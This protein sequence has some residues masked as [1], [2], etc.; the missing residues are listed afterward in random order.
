MSRLRSKKQKLQEF[1]KCQ[2]NYK[3]FLKTYA[4][5]RHPE[6]GLI[7]F[8]TWDFQD[9]LLDK[10]YNHK[11]NIINKSR[12]LGISTVVAGH[13]AWLMCFHRAKN[14]YITSIKIDTAQLMLDMVRTIIDNLPNWFY[15]FF[16]I[17]DNNKQTLSLSN[18]SILKI[19]P[20]SNAARGQALSLMVIDEAA[21]IEGLDRFWAALQP[22]ITAG[23]RC[24]ILSTPNGTGNFFEKE[25]H[26]ALAGE[27]GFVAT[28][29]P[30]WHHPERDEEWE[31]ATRASTSKREF[32]QEFDCDFAGSG[33]TFIAPEVIAFYEQVNRSPSRIIGRDRKIHIFEECDNSIPNNHIL[34]VDPARG[35]KEEGDPFGFHVVRLSDMTQ[36]AEGQTYLDVESVAKDVIE[37]VRLYDDAMIVV[38]NNGG[39]GIRF[40]E[41]IL[42]LGY[43]NI[44][45]SLKNTGEYIEYEF[46]ETQP[47]AV[48]GL[49]TSPSTRV[50]MMDLMLEFIEQKKCVIFSRRFTREMR[51]FIWK[52][53]KPQ[54]R[55]GKHDDLMMSWAFACF[56]KQYISGNFEETENKMM[57]ALSAPKVSVNYLDTTIPG[58]PGF[59]AHRRLA[60]EAKKQKK[61][62]K[63]FMWL[64]MG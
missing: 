25:F 52:N 46:M 4:R 64:Y 5:I 31:K 32:S 49:N 40:I 30:W 12:Q 43:S 21:F 22:T 59:A 2:K 23:G 8:N 6:R 33:D 55:K 50:K 45:C 26:K 14:I 18:T 9:E 51:S 61:N 20:A 63:E 58:M 16:N 27:N 47:S 36:C 37:L 13:I 7:P 41:K 34:V 3:Y 35:G 29:L 53:G 44:Y 39:Y 24:V 56:V 28:E 19:G 60:K 11:L 42:E 17:I 10:F 54:A 57:N 1:K 38:E 15:D 62:Q 48:M